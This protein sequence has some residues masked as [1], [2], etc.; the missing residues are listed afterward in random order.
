MDEE[1]A[2]KLAIRAVRVAIQRDP[3]S[4][5]GVDAV[6]VRESGVKFIK[7]EEVSF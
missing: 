4:G 7:G 2:V 1:D 3:G 6:V 5:E